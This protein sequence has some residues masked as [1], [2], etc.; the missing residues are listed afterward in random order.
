MAK[1]NAIAAVGQAILGLL[2]AAR[3]SPEFAKA[4]FELY[5]GHNFQSPMDKG[6]CLY[7]H[8]ITP[9]SNI[10][11]LPTRLAPNGK[12]F[13]P[14][15]PIDLHYLLI[16]WA[17]E[18]VQQQ[19]LLGWAMR[20][21]ENTPVLSASLLNQHSPEQDTF[22]PSETVDLVIDNIPA[23]EMAAIWEVASQHTQLSVPYV[24]R[25]VRIDSDVEIK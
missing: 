9:S 22:D 20:E 8:R 3:S 6:I 5:Q 13:R 10:R 11:N 15:L 2:S 23:L 7:L 18:P 25:T 24:A 16:A 4:Q 19:L 17:P 21:L 1:H 14:S 12:R